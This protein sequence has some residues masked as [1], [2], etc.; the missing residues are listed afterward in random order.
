LIARNFY[1]LVIIRST[2][3]VISG[4][5][6]ANGINDVFK[7]RRQIVEGIQL[8]RGKSCQDDAARQPEKATV[9]VK[10]VAYQAFLLHVPPVAKL[11]GFEAVGFALSPQGQIKGRF[12][13]TDLKFGTYFGFRGSI[14]AQ[15]CLLMGWP[16]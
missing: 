7:R 5:N 13:Y 8:V 6:C 10:S 9:R 15:P 1:S 12:V 14:F 3:N 16:L 4:Y 2:G 11:P